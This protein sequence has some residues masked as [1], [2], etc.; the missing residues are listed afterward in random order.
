MPMGNLFL[1]SG[2]GWAA[3]EPASSGTAAALAFNTDR[4]E[5]L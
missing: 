1:A 2:C 5:M 3:A 4:R